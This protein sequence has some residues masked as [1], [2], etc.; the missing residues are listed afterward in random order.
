MAG[1]ELGS[2]VLGVRVDASDATKGLAEVGEALDNVASE[3]GD[4]DKAAAKAFDSAS[5]SSKELGKEIGKDADRISRELDGLGG[6][7]TTTAQ[8]VAAA[9][10]KMGDGFQ[11]LDGLK[12][13]T[14]EL[15]SSLKGL[16]GAIGMVS[17]EA[18]RML[19][20]VGE[21]SGGLEASSRL[22]KLAGVSHKALMLAL[23]P[24]SAAVGIAAGAF[25]LMKM[26]Q[27][28]AEEVAAVHRDG[29]I[30]TTNLQNQANSSLRQR[31]VLLG[32][33]TQLE[34][35]RE[36]LVERQDVEHRAQLAE[37]EAAQAA[38]VE[39]T[40]SL[41]NETLTLIGHE[42]TA[43]QTARARLEVAREQVAAGANLRDDQLR[44]LDVIEQTTQATEATTTATRDNTAATQAAS[45][46]AAALALNRQADLE[47]LGA[48]DPALAVFL[49]RSEAIAAQVEAGLTPERAHLLNLQNEIDLEAARAEAL[50]TTAEAVEALDPKLDALATQS[51]AAAEAAKIHAE[52]TQN[53]DDVLAASAVA[54]SGFFDLASQMSGKN[55]EQLKALAIA[56]TTINGLAAGI[57][58]FADLGPVAGGIAAA[59][60]AASTAAALMQIEGQAIPTMHS[61]GMVG[62]GVGDTMINAQSGEAI[63]NRQAVA[64]IGGPRAVEDLN[65]SQGASGG[66]GVVVNL[67][68]R[69]RAFDS[70]VIDNL[71]KGGPLRSAL[72]RASNRGRRRV[73]G[74]L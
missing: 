21:L 61:G 60:I 22:A 45:E 6:L 9:N 14:G 33:M 3:A 51:K 37:Q 39:S 57:K 68:Y 66:G 40:R 26:E 47:L 65:N 31:M 8:D 30:A 18:E 62:G 42:S 38:L 23:G 46:A 70:V 67:S 36:A 49:Q 12:D 19:F 5:D 2:V 74:V 11:G 16:G 71:A 35:N 25:A 50:D 56:E 59:G 44:T 4:F 69:Q 52:A 13:V 15:D 54:M 55:A 20:V 29:L 58:A 63:L 73:G 64:N 72:N 53:G 41:W 28:A 24:L 34:A 7:F 10:D 17:P 27:A 48:V 1:D 43:T 32:E